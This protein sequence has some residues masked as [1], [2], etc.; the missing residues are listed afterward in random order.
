MERYLMAALAV[1]LAGCAGEP[2]P[3]PVNLAVTTDSYCQIYRKL[4]WSPKDTPE[5]VRGIL[6]ANAKYD[7]AC[8]PARIASSIRQPKATP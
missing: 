5:T 7:R 8:G 2:T 1:L 4:S 6:S 3:P